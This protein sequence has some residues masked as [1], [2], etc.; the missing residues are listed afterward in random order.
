MVTAITE[1]LVAGESENDAT[2]PCSRSVSSIDGM[3]E[4]LNVF[5]P[6]MFFHI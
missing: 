2:R 3:S 5:H 1:E 4:A 6:G